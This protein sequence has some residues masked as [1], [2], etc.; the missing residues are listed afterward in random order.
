MAVA[1]VRQH[2]EANIPII[3]A[4]AGTGISAKFEEAGGVDLI[5]IYNSGRFRMAGRGSLAGVMPYGDANAIVMDMAGEVGLIISGG[6]R[7]GA[8]VAKALALGADAV[9]IG[10]A[11]L[12]ALGCNNR[13][14]HDGE[15]WVDVSDDYQQ[16]GTAPGFCHHCQTG[17]CPVGI[18]TQDERLE[19]RLLP[20]KAA[21]WVRNYL[22]VVNME[23]TTLARACGKSDVHH[24]EREDLAALPVEAAA[25]A[26]IPLAGTSWVPGA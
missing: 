4:G 26:R 18:T 22:Q 20:E 23:V 8:D 17:R 11:A 16:L 21:E 12:I 15:G 6:I 24:L 9:S 3:G 2:I 13:C 1:R 5:V 25:M 19:Q 7:T 10:Q 14:H